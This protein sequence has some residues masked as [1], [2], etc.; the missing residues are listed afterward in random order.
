MK[1]HLTYKDDKSDKFW[2]IEVFGE[3][4]MVTFGRTGTS[5]QTQTKT[6][7][8]EEL[9][10]KEAKK[11]HNE[12]LKKGYAEENTFANT[13]SNESE[14][15]NDIPK[16]NYLKKWEEIVHAK[17]WRNALIGDMSPLM[18]R[19]EFLKLLKPIFSRAT[20]IKIENDTLHVEFGD[21]IMRVSPAG[22][23][24][25]GKDTIDV[26][27][28]DDGTFEKEALEGTSIADELDDLSKVKIALTDYSNW[29][30]FHPT[31]KTLKKRPALC[32]LDHAG[33]DVR[34]CIEN[35][36]D[37]VFFKRLAQDL[38]IEDIPEY[39]YVA[40]KGSVAKPPSGDPIFRE[41]NESKIGFRTMQDMYVERKGIQCLRD[42]PYFI[43]VDRIHKNMTSF[44]ISPVP[45]E[46][47]KFSD[48]PSRSAKVPEGYFDTIGTQFF[49]EG[50]K[51]VMTGFE[52]DAKTATSQKIFSGVFNE[53]AELGEITEVACPDLHYVGHYVFKGDYLYGIG[54]SH[55]CS[56]IS[57]KDGKHDFFYKENKVVMDNAGVE[58]YGDIFVSLE[59]V[60]SKLYL[61]TSK[62]AF[63]FDISVPHRPRLL[64]IKKFPISDYAR[65]VALSHL[66]VIAIFPK[67][68]RGLVI[69]D[70]KTDK[71]YD[72]F[73]NTVNV[74][75]ATVYGN[76]L[77]FTM[78][79]GYNQPIILVAMDL[80]NPLV[81]VIRT[82]DLTLNLEWDDV[83]RLCISKTDILILVNGWKKGQVFRAERMF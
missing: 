46:L 17:D 65:S 33:G 47:C 50:K 62:R 29:W 52:K 64:K 44:S 31:I 55:S 58:M 1:H 72:Y 54:S 35:S 22:P 3:S 24:A 20:T 38:A 74:E 77:W 16:A 43:S 45:Q 7:G 32:F 25:F 57:L 49:L 8:S 51:I 18:E 71:S 10:L 34:D 4:F 39:E 68:K 83:G 82:Q 26:A 59:I 15:K 19:P 53:N 63:M 23:Y 81:P 21:T 66:N 13:K 36:A 27:F 67:R 69:W 40:K 2:N 61:F 14:E 78:V 80:T 56:V 42:Q 30:L 6:F 5:G 60:D 73:E 70:T 48:L 12:K 75:N 9:C 37:E 41:F 76:E 79:A 11:L 28:G